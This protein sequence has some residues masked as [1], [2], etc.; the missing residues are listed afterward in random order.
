MKLQKLATFLPILALSLTPAVLAQNANAM[1]LALERDSRL[2]IAY[3]NLLLEGG[4]VTDPEGKTGLTDFLG[5]MLMRG[6]QRH[7]KEALDLLLDQWGAQLAVEARAE[8]LIIRGSVL[9]S[10]LNDFLSLLDEIVAEPLFPETEI[11]K[12][13]K[14]TISELLSQQGNDHAL[15]ARQFTQFLFPGHPYGRPVDGIATQVEKFDRTSLIRQHALLFRERSMTVLGVG[16]IDENGL[17]RWSDSLAQKLRGLEEKMKPGAI[18]AAEIPAAQ[19]SRRLQ[20]VDKP[21]RTQT[22]IMIGQTGVLMTDLDYYALYLGNTAFGGGSFMSRLMQE[23]RVKRGWSYGARSQFRFGL[24]PRSWMVHLFPAEKDTPAALAT[25]LDM[26]ARLKSEGIT[27]QEFD[28]AKKSS[29]NSAAF[30]NDTPKKRVENLILEKSLRL[31][32]GFF[33][34]FAMNL[35]KVTL[36]Q[37][38]RALSKFLDPEHL[39]ITVVGTADHLKKA[40]A[41]KAGISGD[42]IVVTPYTAN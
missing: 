24:Q 8:S 22:Q 2:P 26:I 42:K 5:E 17:R 11:A 23:I 12:L 19:I 29:I 32:K 40:L 18:P 31:P 38:N 25:T 27:Q 9:S 14:E 6:T 4:A 7:S 1:E 20:I 36:S 30:L 3:V 10:K 35:E 37:V 15:A 33:Q 39:T 28:L 16:D 41:E 21:E 34:N 13:K